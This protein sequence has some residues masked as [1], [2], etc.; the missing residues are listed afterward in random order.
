MVNDF[1]D[2]LEKEIEDVSPDNIYNMDES[3]FHDD[4]GKKLLFRRS[5]RHPEQVKNSSK[6]CFTIVFSGN[7]TGDIIPPFFIFKGK[8]YWS[9]WLVNAPKFS[10][11]AVSKSG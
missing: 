11:M 5:T 9:D 8:N 7:A 1:F 6:S 10:K 4:P 2:R 3:G